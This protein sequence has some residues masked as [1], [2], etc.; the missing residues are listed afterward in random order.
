MPIDKKLIQIIRKI[1]E[2]NPKDFDDHN[3]FLRNQTLCKI[4][5]KL[6]HCLSELVSLFRDEDTI[7]KEW[8]TLDNQIKERLKSELITK[9]EQT[10]ERNVKNLLAYLICRICKF[11]I[12]MN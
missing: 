12:G 5:S 8:L 2:Y 7:K 3:F 11:L 6:R 4:N 10:I 9:F 1:Q